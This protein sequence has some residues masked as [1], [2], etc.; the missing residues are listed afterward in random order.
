M[1]ENVTVVA[2]PQDFRRDGGLPD[3]LIVISMDSAGNPVTLDEN[4]ALAV[5][6]H[7]TGKVE[8]LARTFSEY[9]DSSLY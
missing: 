9:V 1:H 7:N 3:G 6:D 8:L 5:H 4:G 2:L